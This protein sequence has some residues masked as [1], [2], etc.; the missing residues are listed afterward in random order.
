MYQKGVACATFFNV[1]AVEAALTP[2][3]PSF[4][5]QVNGD[6]TSSPQYPLIYLVERDDMKLTQ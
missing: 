3:T 5:L 6:D 1:L 4:L 2:K